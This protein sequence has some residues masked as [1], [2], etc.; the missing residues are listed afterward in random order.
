MGD[1]CVFQRV[2]DEKHLVGRV[3]QFSYLEGSKKSCE[4]SS[5][6]VETTKESVNFI[7]VL[8]NWYQGVPSTLTDSSVSFKPLDSRYGIGYLSMGYYKYTIDGSCLRESD[9]FSFSIAETHL[10]AVDENWRDSLSFY[11]DFEDAHNEYNH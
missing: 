11:Y 8:A 5:S 9:E 1:L 10:S 4:Y 7:G 2:D 3:I 6:Y